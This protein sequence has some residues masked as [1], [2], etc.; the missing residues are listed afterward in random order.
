L[1][2]TVKVS[3]C[4][5]EKRAGR[6]LE[7]PSTIERRLPFAPPESVSLSFW[8][9]FGLKNLRVGSIPVRLKMSSFRLSLSLI[10]NLVICLLLLVSSNLSL[11][12]YPRL[13]SSAWLASISASLLR[14][15]GIAVILQLAN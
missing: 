1:N 14:S 8:K 5:V 3:P 2:E 10:L 15:R 6:H 7:S 11:V 9:P 13:S 4:V 12:S